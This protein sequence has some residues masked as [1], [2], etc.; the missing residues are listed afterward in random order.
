[1][2]LA[3]SARETFLTPFFGPMTPDSDLPQIRVFEPLRQAWFL[4]GATASGKTNLALELADQL[5]AEILSLDSMAVYVGMDVGTAKPTPD[6]RCRVP[7]H[8]ID[9]V[10]PDQDFSLSQYVAAAHDAVAAIRARGRSPLFVGGT[11]L[12]LKALLRGVYPGPPADWKFRQEIEREL[13]VIPI[14]A[15]HERLRQ[16]DP[17][18]AAK[19]HPHDKRRIIR[20]LEVHRITGSPI[21]RRQTH[22]DELPPHTACRVVTLSWP[23]SELHRRIEIRVD[24]MFREGLVDEVRGLLEQYSQLSRTAAQ[25]VGYREV[26]EYLQTAGDLSTTIARV[27]TRT[28]QFARRQETWFRSLAECQRCEHAAGTSSSEMVRRIRD[29]LEQGAS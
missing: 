18:S 21:S 11:P 2:L 20:A 27:K 24:E 12:Y 3:A 28:R 10:T 29:L 7:H 19:L 9:L 1:M 22:F 8:L 26:I 14:E 15:L 13:Q 23:R 16:V 25:A 6:Q 17:A 5:D 4:T